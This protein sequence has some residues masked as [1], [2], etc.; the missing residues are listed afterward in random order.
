MVAKSLLVLAYDRNCCDAI[1][2]CYE[3]FDFGVV[4]V[5]V[6]TCVVFLGFGSLAAFH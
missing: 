3:S 4:A 2:R 1:F 5:I 6:C